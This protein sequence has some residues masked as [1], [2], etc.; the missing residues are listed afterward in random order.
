MFLHLGAA[1]ADGPVDDV[2]PEM[3][4]R[5]MAAVFRGTRTVPSP[6]DSR[7]RQLVGVGVNVNVTLTGFR[8]G[9][10]DVRWSL[11][12]ARS[13]VQV[14]RD[15]LR[16]QR[17]LLLRG[18]ADSHTASREFWVPAP[19]SKGPFFIR[20]GVYSDDGERLDYANTDRFR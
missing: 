17:V 13:G 12:S 1:D 10:V 4:E 15:W 16:N 7:K 2:S 5:R 9:K 14:P 8:R 3:V 11:Y 18:E 19:A 20:V 6:S